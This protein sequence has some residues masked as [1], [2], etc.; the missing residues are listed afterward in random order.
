MDLFRVVQSKSLAWRVRRRHLDKECEA[1]APNGALERSARNQP[2]C[3]TRGELAYLWCPQREADHE[4]TESWLARIS[5]DM[6]QGKP[7]AGFDRDLLNSSH[8]PVL[9][10]A[11]LKTDLAR[12]IRTRACR[13]SASAAA[14]RRPFLVIR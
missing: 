4:N 11:V 1:A 14:A 8:L 5:D 9:C 10:Y 12:A 3:G 13:R 6:E 2:W 7:S